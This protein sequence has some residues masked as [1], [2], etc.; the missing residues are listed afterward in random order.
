MSL[1]LSAAPDL[2]G[3]AERRPQL[4]RRAVG[5][6]RAGDVDRQTV[7]A[8]DD[9]SVQRERPLLAGLAV[10]GPEDDLGARGGAV[11]GRAEAAAGDPELAGGGR[12]DLLVGVAGAVVDLHL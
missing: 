7:G 8:V 1:P 2:V 6:R 11:A 4:D 10:A 12:G 9:G 3:A 5:R